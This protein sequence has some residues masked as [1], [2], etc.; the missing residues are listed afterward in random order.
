MK[1]MQIIPNLKSGGAERFVVDLCNLH[2]IGNE[3]ILVVLSPLDGNDFYLHEVNPRVKVISLN[4]KNCIVD[5]Q[6]FFKVYHVIKDERPDIVH[7]HLKS[8]LYSLLAILFIRNVKFLHTIHSNSLNEAGGI[9]GKLVRKFLFKFNFVTP[10]VISQYVQDTFVSLYGKE[11]VM[12]LNGRNVSENITISQEVEDRFKQ[13]RR[14][15]K[16]RVLVNI[17]GFRPQKRQPMLAR[18]AK[19]L[20]EEGY[21]FSVVFI[22]DWHEKAMLEEVKAINSPNVFYIGAVKN[23]LEYLKCS[24]GFCLPSDREGFALSFIEA[25]GTSTVPI[26]SPTGI[27]TDVTTNGENGFIADDLSEESYYRALK[28]YLDT[29][30]NVLDKIKKKA[31]ESYKPY[32]MDNC[33]NQYLQLYKNCKSC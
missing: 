9:K 7:T 15:D 28:Q 14:T 29:P 33:A 30:L 3:V 16:T 2:S 27:M 18:I 1:I 24:D 10:V 31:L 21:D 6:M 4:G 20:C 13:W 22:G 19:R 32:S 23:P 5:R 12:I 11:A 8:I 26:V 17:A 25:L